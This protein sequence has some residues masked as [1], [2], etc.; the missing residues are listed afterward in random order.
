MVWVDSAPRDLPFVLVEKVRGA[1]RLAAVDAR[2]LALG[3]APGGTLADARAQLPDLV[4]I[5]HDP[6][7][8]AR[9]LAALA[10]GCERYTPMATVDAP[11]ALILDITGCLHPYGSEARLAD[12]LDRRL[13]RAGLSSRIAIAGTPDAALALA[14]CGGDDV[15]ALPVTA[16][17]VGDDVHVA[18][19]RAGLRTI[20]DLAD[21]PRGPLAARFGEA[22]PAL[23]ARLLGEADARITPRR[24]LPEIEVEARFAEPVAR[25]EDALATLDHLMAEAAARLN[26]RG[27]GGRA[28]AAALFRSDGHVARMSIETSAPTRDAKVLGRLLRERIDALADPL[29]PGFGYD[30]IRLS[31]PVAEPLAPQQLQL[32]GGEVSQGELTALIDRLT[33]RLGRERVRRFVANDTHIPEQAALELPIA[34]ATPVGTWD[35]PEPGEPPLRPIHMF[36]PPHRI[37]VTAEVP[38]GPPRRFTWRQSQHHVTRYEGP[39]RIAAEWWRRD[40][41]HRPGKAGL[42]RDYYRV[43]DA[44]GRRFWLF[45]HGLY[46]DEKAHPDWYLHGLFA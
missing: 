37:Q 18:L 5:E 6:Q 36:D 4:A 45:R 34:D 31:V 23:L 42:T 35:T 13:S 15:R 12:D 43:E 7:A 11:D 1:M 8:D 40:G 28:F 19:R 25:T 44:R 21:R 33:A 22:M 29:D 41:G 14:R 2:A 26:E 46:G 16:L 39:E 3:I 20:A 24:D 9:L 32:D 27:L 38:D 17:R 10:D 30:L